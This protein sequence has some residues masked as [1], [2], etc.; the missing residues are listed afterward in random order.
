MRPRIRKAVIAVAMLAPLTLLGGTP[1]N[2]D[3]PNAA[4]VVGTGGITPGLT[5]VKNF[6]DVTFA[7]L[8]TVDAGT[9]A[10]VYTLTFSGSSTIKEDVTVGAGSGTLTVNG[11]S[12]TVTYSRNLNVVTVNGAV[13]FA[14]AGHALLLAPCVFAPTSANPTISYGLVCAAVA[15]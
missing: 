8:L 7:G 2:A 4:A 3:G 14:G 15:N 10:G 13:N 9:H 6:Q 11:S 12:S 5:L 1:A